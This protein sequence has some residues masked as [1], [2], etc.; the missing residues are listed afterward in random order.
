MR[1]E[2]DQGCGEECWRHSS[3]HTEVCI[4]VASSLLLIN[5]KPKLEEKNAD[6]QVF[7]EKV[8]SEKD[9]VKEVAIKMQ[10]KLVNNN[11]CFRLPSILARGA[12]YSARSAGPITCKK[13][14]EIVI[15]HTIS[16]FCFFR[17]KMELDFFRLYTTG[18][19]LDRACVPP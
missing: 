7:T 13:E 16:L 12:R 8:D 19:G 10:M 6:V 18:G 4:I 9:K 2:R 14:K 5:K 15:H 11:N 1:E 3:L 17:S